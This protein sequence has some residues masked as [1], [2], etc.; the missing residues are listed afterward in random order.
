MNRC[1]ACMDI[2]IYRNSFLKLVF[3]MFKQ[4]NRNGSNNDNRALRMEV[5]FAM[6]VFEFEEVVC[7][8]SGLDIFYGSVDVLH[9]T[10]HSSRPYLQY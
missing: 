6:N 1:D 7:M 3:T 4:R 10:I 8:S 2:I 9:L 5:P